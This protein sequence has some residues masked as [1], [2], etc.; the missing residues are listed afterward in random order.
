MPPS[1][2]RTSSEISIHALREEG[3]NR[4]AVHDVDLQKFLSTPSARRA[5]VRHDSAQGH[6]G[7]SIHALREEGDMCP[8]LIFTSCRI[9][10]HALREEGD[11]R[12]FEKKAEV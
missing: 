7:I 9:S 4:G 3:D 12:H 2:S 8:L 10:I 5:T 6:G 11:Q 1:A